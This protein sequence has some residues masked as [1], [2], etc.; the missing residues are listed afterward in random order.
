MK[1]NLNELKANFN[2][3][4]GYLSVALLCVLVIGCTKEN[5]V[6]PLAK[7]VE[8]KTDGRFGKIITDDVGRTLYFFS[9]DVGTASTC[10]GGCLTVWPIFHV[11]NIAIGTGLEQADF[12]EITNDGGAK[13]TTY[14]GWPLYYYIGDENAGEITGDKYGDVWYVAKP[15]YA[16]MVAKFRSVKFLVAPKGKTLYTFSND[17]NG[18]SACTSATCATNW[19]SFL[20]NANSSVP[21]LI[22]IND[23]TEI[24][25]IDGRQSAYKGKPLY[26]HLTDLVRGDSTG[27]GLSNGA[28]SKLTQTRF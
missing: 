2:M 6:A 15:D 27:Q 16:V 21:S 8:V 9:T 10:T 4:S 18:A 1:R 20:I 25:R 13:Q 17:T 26:Y 11:D 5:N 24:T 19:P 12:G 3:T 14:K 22:S 23:L 28:F 7:G